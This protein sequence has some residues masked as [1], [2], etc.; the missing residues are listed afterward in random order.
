MLPVTI[1][2]SHMMMIQLVLSK[3][4]ML[5]TVHILIVIMCSAVRALNLQ[6]VWTLHTRFLPV[7]DIIC[8][9]VPTTAV[10]LSSHDYV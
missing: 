5:C 7:D 9:A 8:T 3:M 1:K 4:M 10:T 2:L 6:V